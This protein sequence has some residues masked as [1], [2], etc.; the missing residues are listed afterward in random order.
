VPPSEFDPGVMAGAAGHACLVDC[1]MTD[2]QRQMEESIAW[3]KARGAEA[4][5]FVTSGNIVDEIAAYAAR[6]RIDLIVLGHYPQPSGGL[7]WTRGARSTLADRTN[8]CILVANDKDLG[9]GAG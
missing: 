8:C 6:L 1:K 3:L 7:W 2:H 9:P 5:G 4:E